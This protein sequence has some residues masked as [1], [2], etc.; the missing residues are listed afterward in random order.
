MARI[1]GALLRPPRLL[2]RRR[3]AAARR[4]PHPPHPRRHRAG[5]L[6]RRVPDWT[7]RG[8]STAR[9]P[10]PTSSSPPT[11]GTALSSRPTA[12][13]W[14]RPPT[15]SPV[16]DARRDGD[17]ISPP[18]WPPGVATRGAPRGVRCRVRRDVSPPGRSRFPADRPPLLRCRGPGCHPPPREPC[19]ETP[20]RPAAVRRRDRRRGSVRPA[21]P[22]HRRL[23][24]PRGLR[25]HH[26]L[27]A[28]G[29]LP[30]RVGKWLA[31]HPI[32][33]SERSWASSTW[34]RRRPTSAC[35][36]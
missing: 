16:V 1:G 20:V 3:P 9:G 28:P 2:R 35:C 26:R 23:E 30:L 4:P 34:C 17:P 21:H 10:R 8:R 32:P 24:L 31:E 29:L 12:V 33:P 5:P 19:H 27:T 14:S 25:R 7:A 36:R 6:R 15:G 22:G 13:R 18:S 11:A